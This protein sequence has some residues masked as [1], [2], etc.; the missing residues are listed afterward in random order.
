MAQK[1]LEFMSIIKKEV[2]L[3]LH[4]ESVLISSLSFTVVAF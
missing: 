2:S 1:K 3:N 4:N